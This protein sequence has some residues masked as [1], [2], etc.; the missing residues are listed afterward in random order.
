M[1]AKEQ[2]KR[3]PAKG[4]NL[5]PLAELMEAQR[6]FLQGREEESLKLTSKAI[7]S[8][9]PLPRLRGNLNKI[10]A[11]ETPLSEITLHLTLTESRRRTNQ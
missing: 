8:D 10:F 3:A 4:P 11:G 5:V 7:G 9:E 2:K 6:L 1:E